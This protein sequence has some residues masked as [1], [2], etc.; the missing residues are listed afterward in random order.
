MIL[1]GLKEYGKYNHELTTLAFSSPAP[2]LL[3]S[4]D[5][6]QF[7]NLSPIGKGDRQDRPVTMLNGPSGL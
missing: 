4:G 7:I 3:E 1:S 5:A 2:W 6:S